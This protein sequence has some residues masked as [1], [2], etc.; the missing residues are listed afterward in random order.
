MERVA[1][2]LK[3]SS[4]NMGAARMSAICAELQEVGGSGD[5][6]RAPELLRGLEEEYGRVRP[7]LER[8]ME[9]GS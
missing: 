5:L 4:G 6:T 2:T 9:G 7:A 8:E 1:H 3:G